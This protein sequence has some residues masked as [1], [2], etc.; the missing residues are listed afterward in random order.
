MRRRRPTRLGAPPRPRDRTAIYAK[1]SIVW[2]RKIVTQW[3]EKGIYFTPPTGLMT[4]KLALAGLV[5]LKG[6]D[7]AVS[8]RTL[9]T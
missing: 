2:L 5:Q 8:Q 6:R 1:A 3:N 9:A 4:M 7:F